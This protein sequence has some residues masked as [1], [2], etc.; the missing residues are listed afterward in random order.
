MVGNIKSYVVDASFVLSFLLREEDLVQE[1][2]RD[3]INGKNKFVSS[4]LLKYEVGNSLRSAVVRK[5]INPDT[6][7]KIYKEFLSLQ[8]NEET[9]EILE[10]LKIA[11]LKNL[12]FYDAAYLSL[13]LTKN[14]PLLTMDKELKKLAKD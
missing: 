13:S 3:Y 12:S 2:F 7:E 14:L 9:P 11:L 4:D 1:F 6:A 8:I 10:V 5:K